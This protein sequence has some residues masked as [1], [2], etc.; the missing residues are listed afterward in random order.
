MVCV[1][2]FS[3]VQNNMTCLWSSLM[4]SSCVDL[5][6]SLLAVSNYTSHTHTQSLVV[7]VSE[8]QVGCGLRHSHK[9]LHHCCVIWDGALGLTVCWGFFSLLFL[10]IRV[11][12]SDVSWA[13]VCA[14]C[15]SSTVAAPCCKVL[16]F[17]LPPDFTAVYRLLRA[18]STSAVC[19]CVRERHVVFTVFFS[20]QLLAL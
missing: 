8:D 10:C 9:S 1:C 12:V 11:C 3:S 16:R 18:A 7:M 13:C 17:S 15:V 4:I 6:S 5:E 20:E 14:Q 2:M 19:V